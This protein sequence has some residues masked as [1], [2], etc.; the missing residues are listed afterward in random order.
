VLT[1]SKSLSRLAIAF[2]AAASVAF[3][4]ASARAQDAKTDAD[5]EADALFQEGRALMISDHF[6][7]ACPKLE[8]SQQLSPHGGTL[9]NLAACHERIGRVATAWVEFHQA[10]EAA[11]TEGKT[12]RERLANDRIA[13]LDPRVPWLTIQVPEGVDSTQAAVT[14]DGAGIH[15]NAWGKEMPVDPGEHRVVIAIGDGAPSEV[16]FTLHEGEHKTAQLTAPAPR[17]PVHVDPLP[18]ALPPPSQPPPSVLPGGPVM[19][20]IDVPRGGIVL[21]GGVFTGFLNDG[22]AR[23]T[24]PCTDN[25]TCAALGL[26]DY[27]ARVLFGGQGFVGVSVRPRF[28]LGLR[29]LVSFAEGPGLAMAA[30][31]SLSGRI[32][33]P[34]WAGWSFYVGVVG[35]KDGRDTRS[36]GLTVGNA[37]ELSFEIA[38]TKSGAFLAQMQPT[39]MIGA[40]DIAVMIPVGVAYRFY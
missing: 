2:T 11:K 39:F 12:E 36:T 19:P 28:Q 22:F 17:P 40:A 9:L 25:R 8:R 31:P 30:G 27:H 10:L 20:T 35:I 18:P 15:P 33:G 14:L 24:T 34:I 7:E 16:A 4:A 5:R 1:S 38:K 32:W 29:G 26:E 3:S 13:A 6:A 21:E 37:L 23:S